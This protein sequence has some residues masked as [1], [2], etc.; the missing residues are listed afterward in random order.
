MYNRDYSE[1]L[2]SFS[3]RFSTKGIGITL[4]MLDGHGKFV[5]NKRSESA[6]KRTLGKQKRKASVIEAC[7]SRERINANFLWEF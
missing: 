1:I 5:L 7:R 3:R 6:G 2:G 4:E